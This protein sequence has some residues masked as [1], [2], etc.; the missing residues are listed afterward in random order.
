MSKHS[1]TRP[2][3]LVPFADRVRYMLA[4][5]LVM[6][7]VIA[8]APAFGARDGLS[9]SGLVLAVGTYVVVCVLGLVLPKVHRTLAVLLFGFTLMLDGIF[10]GVT[11]YATTVTDSPLRL[12]LVVYLVVVALVASFRTGLKAVLWNT[13]VLSAVYQLQRDGVIHGY[14]VTFRQIAWFAAMVCLATLATAAFAAVNERELRRRNYDLEALG[15]LSW[16]LEARQSPAEIAQALVDAAVEA[17]SFRRCLVAAASTGQLSVLAA[18]GVSDLAPAIGSSADGDRLVRV[19]M[20]EHR[21]LL[22]VQPSPAD[23][24]WLCAVLPNAQG[25]VVV[26]MFAEGAPLGVFVAEQGE[27]RGTRVERRVVTMVERFVSQS[28][29]ALSSTWLLERVQALAA[30]D[31]LT[32]LANRRTFDDVLIRSFTRA[33]R[34]GRP[35]GL[36]MVDIDLF[37]QV[38]DT[39]GHPTGDATL[40]RVAN[41]LGGACRPHDIVARYGGEEFAVVLP[42]VDTIELGTVAERLRLAVA[43]LREEPPVTVSI[44]GAAFPAHADSAAALLQLADDALYMAKRMGRNRVVIAQPATASRLLHSHQATA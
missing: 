30:T 14:A 22:A 1:T 13:L 6:A 3:H 37:K 26:P 5:R 8:V 20:R 18:H 29:L 38:N 4:F 44:G 9:T 2:E 32:H 24:P 28:S 33:A 36:L 27:R 25:V 15:E 17:F 41:A 11:V 19:S 43:S 7:G 35:L 34:S 23:D 42:D 39:F 31:G 10:L 21:R 16:R 12:L 40:Q